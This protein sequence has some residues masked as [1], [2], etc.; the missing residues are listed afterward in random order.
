[1]K[2]YE[3]MK[4]YICIIILLSFQELLPAQTMLGMTGLLS[5]PSAD[6]QKDKTVIFGTGFLNKEFTPPMF[7]YNTLNYYLNITILPFLEVG[8]SCTLF[9]ATNEFIPEKKGRFVNQDR[10]LSFRIRPVKEGKYIPAFVVGA[11]DVTDN[12]LTSN[13]TNSFY[14]GI[15]LA[16]TKHIHVK[17]EII[18]AHLAYTYTRRA[19]AGVEGLSLGFTYIPSFAS[20]LN[21]T[22]ELTSKNI[23][24]GATY[25]LLKHLSIQCLLQRI[26]Y[27]SGGVT[28]KVYLK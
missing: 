19:D 13:S 25:L 6:M 18:G 21:I 9:K 15:Y 28:Y 23:N 1:M 2:N 27:F 17:K 22:T 26:Q 16:T 14:S 11:T 4:L 20:D 5:V 7:N 12:F 3:R 10:A 24:I 8:Y